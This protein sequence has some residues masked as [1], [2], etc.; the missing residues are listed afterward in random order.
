MEF[1]ILPA[2][3]KDLG[4]LRKLEQACFGKDAW[5]LLDLMG[6]LGLPGIVRL[7]AVI[8]ERMV[9]FIA[10][11]PKPWEVQGWITTVGVQPEYRRKGIGKALIL[12]CEERMKMPKVR[13]SV[14]KPMRRQ[15]ACMAG[16]G[17]NKWAGGKSIIRMEKMPS[18]SK[19]S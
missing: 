1:S 13:L 2:N 4:E 7:K 14:R 12:E 18:F 9:G 17:I 3:L 15:S 6:V 8:D 16:W 19:R 5:P 11:D 10:G